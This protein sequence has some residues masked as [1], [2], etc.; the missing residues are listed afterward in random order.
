VVLARPELLRRLLCVLLFVM[1]TEESRP[2]MYEGHWKSPF[3]VLTPLVTSL[4]G[5]GLSPWQLVLLALCPVCLVWRSGFRRRSLAMD[6]AIVVRVASVALTFLWGAA[7][8]GDS[9]QAYFQLGSFLTALLLGFMLVS[10]VRRPGDLKDL[11]L[12][13]LVAAL[14]RGTLVIHFYFAHALGKINPLPSYM[15]CHEDSLLFVAGLLVVLSWALARRTWPAWIAALLVVAFLFSAMVLNARRLAWIE[16]LLAIAFV[17]LLPPAGTL[18]R[19]VNLALVVV[20]PAFVLYA[21]VGWGRPEAV[22]E[23]LRALSS[24]GSNEDASSLARLE[25][26]RNL[27]YTLTEWGNPLL[28][29]GWGQPYAKTSSVYANFG[30]E[31]SQYRYLPHNSL[32]AVAAFG[33]LVGLFGMWMVVP[34]TAFL[35]TRGYAGA[36]KPIGRA[37]GMAAVCILPAFGAHCY[38]DVGLQQRSCTLILGV[39]M[40]VAARLSV[41]SE[42]ATKASGREPAVMPECRAYGDG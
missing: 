25:E 6:A 2:V 8:G 1:W 22:C 3:Q 21:F 27:M 10:V 20:G 12:T 38:G 26:M 31:W 34:V 5:V 9:Y 7:R 33:G 24:S 42:A 23:P 16:L 36:R 17:Y 30:P 18:R 39:A 40:A 29:T 13:V 37:A 15:T 28:G 14:T 19:R 4:G 35:G 41:W 11:G 32:L